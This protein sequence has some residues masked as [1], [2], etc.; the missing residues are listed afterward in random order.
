ME[1]NF[2]RRRRRAAASALATAA[3]VAGLL[4]SS[5][6]AG[7]TA[8]EPADDVAANAAAVSADTHIAA[9][10]DRPFKDVSSSHKFAREIYWMYDAR[11]STGVMGPNGREYRPSER[12]T[13]EAMAAFMF[14]KYADPS[15]QAPRASWFNDVKTD[16]KF[17]R[18][19]S[20][21]YEYG[22]SKGVNNEY[23]GRIYQPKAKLSREAM[24][25]FMYRALHDG[26]YLD[27]ADHLVDVDLS[28][29]PFG[30]EIS[31]MFK[32]GLSTGIKTPAGVAYQPKGNLSREAMA[33]FMYR[34][35]AMPA[36]I[37]RIPNPTPPPAPKP[38]P[39]PPVVAP[40]VTP[41]PPP[42]VEKYFKNCTE[43]WNAGAAPVRRGDPGY[44]RHLDRDGDGVGCEK[45]P[46]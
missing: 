21:M 28:S 18:E 14:R 13:R 1:K 27:P 43:A 15:Y 23:D 26:G 9:A 33:A 22:L 30:G 37:T 24:A 2:P 7:A 5:V 17:Y 20:W 11:L 25:A 19:I 12:L 10:T 46:R 41:P 35:K 34:S 31:W 38:R 6:S 45:R 44:G 39:K 4:L 8:L 32:A 16:A 3:T 40:P 36:E 42:P 29:H